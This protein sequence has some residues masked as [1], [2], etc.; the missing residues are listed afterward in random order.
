[1]IGKI[2][3]PVCPSGPITPAIAVPPWLEVA[4]RER[5]HSLIRAVY[6]FD[7]HKSGYASP[8]RR[9]QLCQKKK[10]VGCILFVTGRSYLNY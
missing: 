2:G 5:G 3:V 1:M 8:E 6:I 4:V 9:K 10:K 7:V